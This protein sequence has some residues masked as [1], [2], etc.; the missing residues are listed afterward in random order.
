MN[1]SVRVLLWPARAQR[2]EATRPVAVL[3][4]RSAAL[5][6]AK[7]DSVQID[8]QSGGAAVGDGS[9]MTWRFHHSAPRPVE[10]A[11]FCRHSG[12]VTRKVAADDKA[13]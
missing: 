8:Q 13:V 6:V 2:R 1:P 4:R 5:D 11:H 12:L 9:L 10:E 3:P 7:S